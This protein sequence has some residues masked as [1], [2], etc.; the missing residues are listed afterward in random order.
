MPIT[1]DL[2]DEPTLFWSNSYE[3]DILDF[4]GEK[5]NL[6]LRSPNFVDKSFGRA[7]RVPLNEADAACLVVLLV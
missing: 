6:L 4:M 3:G 1:E 7:A 5:K 2:E